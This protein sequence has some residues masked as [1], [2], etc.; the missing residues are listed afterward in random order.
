[1][2]KQLILTTPYP[3]LAKK[4]GGHFHL[5]ASAPSCQRLSRLHGSQRIGLMDTSSYQTAEM[6][7]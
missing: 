6:S 4:A 3:S 7:E 5:A 1:M 2:M